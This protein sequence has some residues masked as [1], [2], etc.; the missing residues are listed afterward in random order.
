MPP[1]LEY[2]AAIIA[3]AVEGLLFLWHLE[4]R[5]PM[6]VQVLVND[7]ILRAAFWNSKF[8]LSSFYGFTVWVSMLC[9]KEIGAKAA[10]KMLMKLTPVVYFSSILRTAFSSKIVCRNLQ[11]GFVI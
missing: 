3:Y 2:A 7:N 6:D 11:L 1:Q 5:P 8:F 10:Y 9:Q 4:G